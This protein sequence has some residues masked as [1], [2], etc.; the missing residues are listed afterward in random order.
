MHSNKQFSYHRFSLSSALQKYVKYAWIMQSK[1]L[2]TRP[3][4]LIADGYPEIIFVQ[5]GAYQ[6]AFIDAEKKAVIVDQS[7]VVGIQTQ[8]ALVKR[9][10][11]CQLIGI[12]LNP[13]GA[14]VLLG[15]KLPQI[16]DQNL[17]LHQFGLDWLSEL[18]QGL[19][20]CHS[21]EAVSSLI[22]ATFLTQTAH[23]APGEQDAFAASILQFILASKGQISVG[24]LAERYHLSLRQLQRKFKKVF[25]ISPKKF[26]NLIRFKHLYKSSILKQKSPDSYLD[27]GYYDQM[28]F[29]KDFKK[30]MGINPSQ[31]TASFFLRMNEIAR[32]SS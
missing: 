29:I 1:G 5:R 31:S 6:K 16:V 19:L 18:D 11:P 2:S 10:G 3:D 28:H 22:S 15:K 14:Y 25:G 9:L 12:K 7:C 13:A 26:I 17:A 27:H 32:Q 23:L 8:S 4:L 24:K 30:Q 21:E 20:D